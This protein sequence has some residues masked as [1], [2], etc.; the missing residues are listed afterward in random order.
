MWFGGCCVHFKLINHI[1]TNLEFPRPKL[2]M[3]YK[4]IEQIVHLLA[5]RLKIAIMLYCSF[6]TVAIKKYS[7]FHVHAMGIVPWCSVDSCKGS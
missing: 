6:L 3:A 4:Y 5:E 1:D 7:L 2:K